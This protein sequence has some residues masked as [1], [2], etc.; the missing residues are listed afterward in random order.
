M[1]KKVKLNVGNFLYSPSK[2]E[3]TQIN[4]FYEEL[5]VNVTKNTKTKST[6]AVLAVDFEDEIDGGDIIDSYDL[7][8]RDLLNLIKNKQLILLK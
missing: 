6:R 8:S 5:L 2:N 3:I 4:E 1:A 7:D